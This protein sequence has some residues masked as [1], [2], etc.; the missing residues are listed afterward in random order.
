MR[1]VVFGLASGI[2]CWA[3]LAPA[4]HAG[5]VNTVGRPC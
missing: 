3:L 2:A 4:A 5:D 1:N